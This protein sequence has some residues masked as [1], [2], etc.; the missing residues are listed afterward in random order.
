LRRQRKHDVEVWDKCS[1]EHLSH[2]VLSPLMFWPAGC[3]VGG[4]R[5]RLEDHI[6]N[7]YR[8]LRKLISPGS[9]RQCLVRLGSLTSQ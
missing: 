7:H 2:Y 3:A 9:S 1:A 4:P 8:D 6:T 5:A